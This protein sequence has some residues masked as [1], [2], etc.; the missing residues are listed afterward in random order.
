VRRRKRKRIGLVERKSLPKP[1]AANISWSLDFLPRPN[2]WRTITMPEHG[3]RVQEYAR[4]PLDRTEKSYL[5]PWTLTTDG[6][7]KVSVNR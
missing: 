3:G 5:Y 6:T 7:K 1:A 2:R 4:M